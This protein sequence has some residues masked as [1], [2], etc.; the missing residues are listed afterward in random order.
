MRINVYLHFEHGRCGQA[1]ARY[2]E[3]LGG[4]ITELMT[5]GQSP[6]AAQAPPE[7]RDWI[8]HGRLDL[9]DGQTLMGSDAP[10]AFGAPMRGFS[11]ALH[12]ATEAEAERV[13]AGLAE[14]GTVHMALQE[15]FWAKR[16]GMVVDRF[17]TPWLINCAREG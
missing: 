12:P 3:L 14:D 6:M 15:T 10:P 1:L 17:G 8:M 9:A 13:F 11:V 4:R 5:Y 2:A 7:Q 16:F